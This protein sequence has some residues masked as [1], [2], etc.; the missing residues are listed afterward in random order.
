MRF[1]GFLIHIQGAAE[2]KLQRVSIVCRLAI[3]LGIEATGIGDVIS[4]FQAMICE[5][6]CYK[7]CHPF[8]ATAIK[9]ISNDEVRLLCV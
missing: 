5:I 4:D 2:L 9:T 8:A 7:L 6:I 1:Q 3:G